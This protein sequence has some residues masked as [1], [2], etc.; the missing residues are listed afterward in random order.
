MKT[1][2]YFIV[3]AKLV[4]YK[5]SVYNNNVCYLIKL[6]KRFPRDCSGE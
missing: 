2:F 5:K 1:L 3:I 6:G 4:L